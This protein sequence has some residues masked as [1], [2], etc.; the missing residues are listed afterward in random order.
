MQHPNIEL[1]NDA[2]STTTSRLMQD[3]NIVSARGTPTKRRIVVDQRSCFRPMVHTENHETTG[4]TD[5]P[6]PKN[7]IVCK[8]I[9]TLR[10]E[11]LVY[12]EQFNPPSDQI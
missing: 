5:E 7:A 1:Q 11:R 8:G 6:G 2:W 12:S 4:L 3:K 9:P 10:A